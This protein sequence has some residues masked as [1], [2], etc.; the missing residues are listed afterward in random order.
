MRA[1]KAGDDAAAKRAGDALRSSHQW[2]V[3]NEMNDDGDWPEVFWETADKVAA[4]ESS[5]GYEQALGCE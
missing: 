4:G 1:R 3:L 5:T 2:K